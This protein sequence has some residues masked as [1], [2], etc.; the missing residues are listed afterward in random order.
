[1][2]V[3]SPT[4]REELTQRGSGSRE[5]I[6]YLGVWKKFHNDK[7]LHWHTAPNIV[8]FFSDGRR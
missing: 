3:N 1:V 5:L 2:G 4:L 8:R 7:L 6:K